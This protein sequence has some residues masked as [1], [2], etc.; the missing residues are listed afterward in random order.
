MLKQY[1]DLLYIEGKM[2]IKARLRYKV[3][4]FSDLLILSVT[5][6]LVLNSQNGNPFLNS[7][8]VSTETSQL[9]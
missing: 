4:L 8:G 1:L 9:K 5:F 2:T 7:Y 3:R 6:I